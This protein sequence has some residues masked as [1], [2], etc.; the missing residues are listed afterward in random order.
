MTI[1]VFCEL[2]DETALALI[3]QAKRMAP[4]AHVIALLEER[5]AM[6]FA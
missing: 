1:V 6:R 4:Q 2:Q 3:A 5:G